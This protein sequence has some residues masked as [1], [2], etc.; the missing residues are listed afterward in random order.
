MH[1]ILLSMLLLAILNDLRLSESESSR[2]VFSTPSLTTSAR[3]ALSVGN[4]FGISH[5]PSQQPAAVE[6]LGHRFA[7]AINIQLCRNANQMQTEAERTCPARVQVRVWIAYPPANLPNCH[8][9]SFDATIAPGED[10][11][12][13][14]SLAHRLGHLS[15]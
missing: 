1:Y 7:G 11:P 6:P 8:R 13:P 10:C 14:W 12:C 2:L 4:K 9:A 5:F 15:W 3:F